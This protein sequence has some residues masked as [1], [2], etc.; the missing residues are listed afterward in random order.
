MKHIHRAISSTERCWSFCITPDECASRPERQK[1]HGGILRV[2]T[3][4][5]GAVRQGEINFYRTNYGPW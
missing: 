2:D 4:R 1:A 5:C 3:C